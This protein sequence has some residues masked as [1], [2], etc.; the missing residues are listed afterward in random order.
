MVYGSVV[1]SLAGHDKNNFQ[2]VIKTSD[3]FAYVCDG[4]S[5]PLEKPKKKNIKHLKL[6]NTVLSEKCLRSNKSVRL[7]LRSFFKEFA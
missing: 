7:A 1:R 4:K 2:V 3:G 5:R 6:L